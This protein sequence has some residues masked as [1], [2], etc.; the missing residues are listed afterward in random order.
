MSSITP[1]H[2]E[3]IQRLID[4][5]AIRQCLFRYCRGIDRADEELLRSTYWPD[6][7]DNHGPYRGNAMGFVDWAMKTLP[8]IERGIHQIHNILIEFDEAGAFVESYFSAF[9]RQYNAQKT[10]EQWD[11]KGR[12]LDRFVER[13]G[14]WRVFERTV[15]FD[16]VEAMPLPE[17]TEKE[18]FGVRT[19]I[20]KA[21]PD[22]LIYSLPEL[23]SKLKSE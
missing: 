18:R 21:F 4:S 1:S 22:D 9:Q 15:V 17:G 5:E 14:E 13:D 11:M 20:G 23:T 2:P 12:Y 3:D 10:L 16:W 19:P 8:F 6:G 7:T